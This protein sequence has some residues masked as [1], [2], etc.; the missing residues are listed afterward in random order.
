VNLHRK[1]AKWLGKW[2]IVAGVYL[3]SGASVFAVSPLPGSIS[4][5]VVN[6]VGN[7]ARTVTS[8]NPLS[9]V[10]NVNG[11]SVE[12]LDSSAADTLSSLMNRAITPGVVDG[13]EAGVATIAD[14]VGIEGPAGAI[15]VEA[16]EVIGADAVGAAVVACVASIVCA[17]GVAAVGI[18]VAALISGAH[19]TK[20]P[21]GISV[22]MGVDPSPQTQWSVAWGGTSHIFPD[23]SSA[24]EAAFPHYY[25]PD[26]QHNETHQTDS[27]QWACYIVVTLSGYERTS[28]YLYPAPVTGLGC[29]PN[30][31]GSIPPEFLN[32]DGQMKC[33]GG[34]MTS[35]PDKVKKA[36][37]QAATSDNQNAAKG[38]GQILDGGGSIDV[39]PTAI[40][41]PASQNGAS[42]TSVTTAPDGSTTTTTM[43]KHYDLTYRPDAT[44]IDIQTQTHTTTSTKDSS[45]HETGSTDTT[46]STGPGSTGGTG[47]GTG[48]GTGGSGGSDNDVD[49]CVAHPGIIA[50]EQEGTPPTDGPTWQNKDI[51]FLPEDLGLPSG[52]PAPRAFTVRGIV[53]TLNYQPACDIAPMVNP[54]LVAFA[55]LG[56]LLWVIGQVKG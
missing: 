56:C 44:G 2:G 6:A 10:M 26:N 49:I 40:S 53:F 54:C 18:G 24:C 8:S 55:A 32:P 28:I 23:P 36:I 34:E 19:G 29:N 11:T 48:T 39:I 20:G 31:D 35:D 45:G 30:P 1:I 52:C 14:T 15:A 7:V 37:A 25:G 21:N 22:D 16:T 27:G 9:M 50:C 46:T 5:Q 38:V 13:A 12:V 43:T 4:G 41:G 51:T 3:L 47:T 17:A 42:T 33:P